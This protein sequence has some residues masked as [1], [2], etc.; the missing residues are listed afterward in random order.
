MLCAIY[1]DILIE[2]YVIR[3]IKHMLVVA[4]NLASMN[5]QRQLGI[6]TKNKAKA[7]E[8]LSSGFDINRAADNAAGL[9]ISEKMRRLIRGFDQGTRNAEDGISWTQIGDGALNEAHDILHRMNELSIQALNET[10]SEADRMML[11]QEFDNLQTELDRISEQTLFNEL[12][13]FKEHDATYYKC[14]GDIKWEPGQVHVVVDGKNDLVIKYREREN[15]AQKTMSITVPAGNYTTQELVDEIDS[16]LEKAGAYNEDIFFEFTQENYCNVNYEGGQIIDSVSG[17]L[18]YL[19][20][21]MYEGGDF[22]A[23]IGTTD[24]SSGRPL[25]ISSEN[26]TMTFVEEDFD[27]NA[28]EI[29]LVIPDGK[30]Y[31]DELI[32]WFNNELDGTGVRASA[33]GN[34]I[35]LGSDDAIVT[36][37]KGNMFKIDS[38]SKPAS[39]VFYDNVS[40]GSVTLTQASFTGGYVLTSNNIDEE[41]IKYTITG[42]NNT[43]TL[44]PNAM[45]APVTITIPEGRYSASEMASKLNDLFVANNLELKAST[46][47][48]Y[49][50]SEGEYFSALVITSDVEGLDSKIGLDSSSSAYDT[51]F[52]SKTYNDYGTMVVPSNENIDDREANFT[53]SKDLSGLSTTP[54]TV[55]STNN[56]FKVDI[57]GDTYNITMT[58]G[59]YSSVGDIVSDINTQLTTNAAITLAGKLEAVNE[60][61]KISIKVTSGSGVSAVTVSAVSGNNGFEDIFQGKSIRYET[62]NVNGTG[63]V[64]LNKPYD[65]AI[66]SG[67]NSLD[68]TVNGKE[69]TVQLP[70]GNPTQSEIINVIET[71]IPGKTV[72]EVNKF[73]QTDAVGKT[74]NNSMPK[75]TVTGGQTLPSWSASDTGRTTYLEGTTAIDVDIPAKITV[76]PKLKDTMVVTDDSN[77]VTLTINGATAKIVLDNGTYTKEGLV[78]ALQSKIDEKCG[79]DFGGVIVS[80]E[81]ENLVFT[82]RITKTNPGE[83]SSLSCSVAT[84]SFIKELG[85]TRTKASWTSSLALADSVVIDSTSNEF[86]FELKESGVVRNVAVTLDNGTYTKQGIVDEINKKLEAQGIAVTASI[87]SDKLRLTTDEAGTGAGISYGTAIGGSSGTVLFGELIKRTPADKVV[88]LKTEDSIVIDNS[89]NIFNIN[90]NGGDYSVILDDGTYTREQFVSMLNNKLSAANAGVEAYVS[91]DKLGYKT[92]SAGNQQSFCIN[93]D[94]GGTSMKAIYGETTTVYPGVKAS[95]T[96]DGNLKLETSPSANIGVSSDRGSCFQEPKQIITDIPTTSQTGYSSTKQGT[97]DGVSLSGDVV[98]DEYNDDLKFVF[99]D[100]G[101]E[102]T[103][104]IDVPDNTYTYADL[105]KKLQELLDAKA[106]VGKLTATVDANG[107]VIK[108]VGTGSTN[109]LTE[110]SGGFYYEVISQCTEKTVNQR[111][112]NKD[113]SQ[114]VNP[115]FTIGRKDVMS[116]GVEIKDGISDKLTIDLTYAGTVHTLEIELDVG[117]YS[118]AGIQQHIQKKLNEVLV[119]NG[120]E[121]NL[122]EVGLGD[123]TTGIVGA[124]DDKALNFKLSKTAKV[125]GEGEYI[126]DGVGGN[127]AFEVF[128]KT[129]GELIPAYVRGSKDVS[130]GVMINEGENELHFKV[131]DVEYDITLDPAYYEADTLIKEINEKL[132]AGSIPL[133]ATLDEGRVKISHMKLG[134]HKIQEISGSARDDVFFRE[135]GEDKA[136]VGVN[137]QLSSERED[138]VEIP[139]TKV[140]TTLL[141]INS[142]CISQVKYATKAV[143]RISEA[144]SKVSDIRSILGSSQNKLEHAINSNKNKAE[145]T[146]AAE[147][148]IRDTDMATMMME[149]AKLNILQ[150]AGEAM[151][152][153]ANTSNEGILALL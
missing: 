152:A 121:E 16:A 144:I 107:V 79:T 103:I 29:T 145:N 74:T 139:R 24:F 50:Y 44:Q 130:N 52:V 120:F 81:G 64:T 108:T 5:T 110:P 18:S 105:Q 23:L 97:I 116:E 77:T 115:A 66:D 83:D 14:Y 101:V 39:S 119:A 125:P 96:A 136:N 94:S 51:L 89:S 58:A 20:Y 36:K 7:T 141:G 21:D 93:Y 143:D 109:R 11:Q 131:D 35:K 10:N 19:L 134:D 67:D 2:Y 31:K 15:D 63:S 53:G 6:N 59:T 126:I 34:G 9:A 71:T 99:T 75:T 86:S 38:G 72:T 153:H 1:A 78:N 128:Y 102:K 54:L 122:I 47:S 61:G 118:G 12:K 146:T 123:L 25:T 30:Y 140:S 69:Y 49:D 148:R 4:H 85:T 43:L 65:G 37:F 84:S 117:V 48:K 73:S 127:A 132:G 129:D 8:K 98:I 88:N 87:S 92:V 124:N 151:L 22:G 138:N 100:A 114:I 45:D 33:F 42:A 68:I 40:Y 149:Q 111:V 46:A 57:D 32:E 133:V 62:Q 135:Y 112:T 28:T 91:G 113:G 147:S 55:D 104:E 80:R 150:Q 56:Q 137:I 27:G 26:N 41:H 142:I 106:G 60:N 95:F 76:G 3:R 90:V 82:A 17:T 70:T 13:I